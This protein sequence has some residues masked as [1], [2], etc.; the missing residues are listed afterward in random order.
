MTDVLTQGPRRGEFILSEAE[1]TLSRETGTLVRGQ[2]LKAGTVLELDNSGKLTAFT[3]D[4]DSNGDLIKDACGVLY[5]SVDA[6]SA[7][8]PAAYIARDAEVKLAFLTY[9]AETSFGD[10]LVHTKASLAKLHVIYR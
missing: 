7:D 8:T 1:G 2:N 5:D 6:S 9:P 4:N 10:E 3:G